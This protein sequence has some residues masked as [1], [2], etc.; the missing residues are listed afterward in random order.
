MVTTSS[1]WTGAEQ[2]LSNAW[3]AV[4]PFD[5]FFLHE[6]R[7]EQWYRDLWAQDEAY[8]HHKI[9]LSTLERHEQYPTPP[10]CLTRSA[11]IAYSPSPV[12]KQMPPQEREEM[13]A[14][15]REV[16]RRPRAFTI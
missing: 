8:R 2:A 14:T 9:L 13:R 7:F 15:A 12:Q 10:K 6:P 5:N 1:L 11:S 4:T 16:R 3:E